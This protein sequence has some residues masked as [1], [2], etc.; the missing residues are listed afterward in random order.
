MEIRGG[1]ELQVPQEYRRARSPRDQ[2]PLCVDEGIQV[3]HQRSDCEWSRLPRERYP[4]LPASGDD[5]PLLHQ[6][7]VARV[8]GNSSARPNQLTDALF[9]Q[10]DDEV[11]F[12]DIIATLS[13]PGGLQIFHPIPEV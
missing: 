8:E 2:A 5:E 4:G 13:V 7:T 10:L 9:R 11:P 6:P 12:D 3:V 1:L